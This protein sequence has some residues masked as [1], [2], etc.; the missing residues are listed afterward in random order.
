MSLVSRVPP[1]LLR[2]VLPMIPILLILLILLIGIHISMSLESVLFYILHVPMPVLLV[3]STFPRFSTEQKGK[4]THKNVETE[5]NI[6][7][8]P[9]VEL[10]LNVG[11]V[12]ILMVGFSVLLMGLLVLFSAEF[13]VS[14]R[15]S[16]LF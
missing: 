2:P 11:I 14:F 8:F 1:L 5:E 3:V 6:Y 15:F 4:H 9:Y 10:L 7:Q 12:E 13:L 16:F